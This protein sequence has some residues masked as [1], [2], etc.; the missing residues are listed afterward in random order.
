MWLFGDSLQ[1][2]IPLLVDALSKVSAIDNKGYFGIANRTL[3]A[4]CQ[5]SKDWADLHSTIRDGL[6]QYIESLSEQAL[7]RRRKE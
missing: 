7:K 3:L 1:F 2:D 6:P 5:A 4:A